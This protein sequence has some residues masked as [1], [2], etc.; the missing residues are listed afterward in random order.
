MERKVY[1]PGVS[2]T[3]KFS[4]LSIMEVG[5]SIDECNKIVPMPLPLGFTW[6]QKIDAIN[7]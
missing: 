7:Q 2:R 6:R 4:F 3:D 1:S 5:S